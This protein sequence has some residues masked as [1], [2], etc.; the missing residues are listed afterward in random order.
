M[1]KENLAKI[2]RTALTL[3]IG[4]GVG[5]GVFLGVS[6]LI[7]KNGDAESAATTNE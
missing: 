3:L 2:G 4:A 7:K 1:T 5:I 6:F